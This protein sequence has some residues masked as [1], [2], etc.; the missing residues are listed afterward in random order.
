MTPPDTPSPIAGAFDE[1]GVLA[2]G[3]QPLS[4]V[5]AR[6]AELTKQVLRVP[7]E[8][9]VTLIEPEE[10]TTPAFTDPLAKDL[11]ET[12]YTLG[13]GPCLA[14]AE[15]GQLISIGDTSDERRWPE[16]ADAAAAKGIRSTLS[17]PLPV[18]RQVIG[19]LNLYATE[20]GVFAPEVVALAEQFGDYAAVA[21]ANTTL[22]MSAAQLA[23]QMHAAM[24]SRAVIEQAKGMLMVQ[25]KCDAD[26]AFD[27]LVQLSQH[28]HRKLRDVAQLIVEQALTG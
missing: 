7:A 9:S 4:D 16:F 25:R 12:Q 8:A 19:A 22:Y 18:Q 1:L 15:G 13:Y 11:D 5:L 28:S 27:I 6:T 23:G 3:Q 14:A 2:F 20:H 21:I 26:A 10:A 24:T 17:V